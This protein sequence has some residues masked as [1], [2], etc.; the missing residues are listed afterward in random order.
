VAIASD[1]DR[2]EL[3]EVAAEQNRLAA[4]WEMTLVH[5]AHGAHLTIDE[6]QHL[7]VEHGDFVEDEHLS[8][9]DP[10]SSLALRIQ[11]GR[12]VGSDVEWNLEGAVSC[13]SVVHQDGGDS[14]GC[15][16]DDDDVLRSQLFDEGV[17]E[18]RLA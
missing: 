9:G 17:V 10:D 7:L 5:R 13:P 1:D 8:V 12:R 4:E 3:L 11:I 6:G 16:G 2:G 15:G 18:V 14:S